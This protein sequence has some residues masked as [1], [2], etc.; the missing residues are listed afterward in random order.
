MTE[1]FNVAGALLVK[2]FGS[3]T[4]KSKGS[5]S[6]AG[7]V[8]DIGIT[9]AMYSRVFIV[10]LL[11]TASLA[12][13]LVYGWGGVLAER[14]TLK[15]GTVVALTAYLTRLYGPLTALSN[16]QVDVMTALVSFDRVFEVLDLP[17][18]IDEKP[19]AAPDPARPGHSSSSTTSTSATRRRG[20][21]P[22]L[23][24]VGGRP[25]AHRRHSQ[26]LFDVT[27][28]AQPGQLVALVGPVG[29]GQDDHQPSRPPALRRAGRGGA[30]QRH[31]RARRHLR[32]GPRRRRRGHPGRPPVPRHD[33]GQPALRQARRHRRR[34]AR[35]PA[36]RRRSCRWSSRCPT[37]STPSSATAATG[38]PA[39]RSSASPSPGCCSR[40]RTSSSSTRPPPTWTPSPRSP[41]SRPSR[42]PWPGAPRSSSP[43]GSRP[44][45]RRTR[46]WSSRRAGSSSG[47][48]TR[49]CSPPAASTPSSTRRSSSTSPMATSRTCDDT[50]I[51]NRSGSPRPSALGDGQGAGTGTGGGGPV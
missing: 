9:Q 44:C 41:S 42:R 18:M 48:A 21:L 20:G 31:R 33:P 5:R 3:P 51:V 11:L 45:A 47:D 49:S 7:R 16:V 29:R 39:A 8:R 24:R 23:A 14:G 2:L 43:T 36:R 37:G 17:P 26:V 27:F 40:P 28:T 1:R 34:A 30:H 12:T 19:D 32:V 25:R 13:A 6:Q 35:G 46:S 22:G 10:A 4:T 50:E 15:I 38:S